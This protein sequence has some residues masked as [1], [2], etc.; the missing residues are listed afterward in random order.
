MLDIQDP[1]ITKMERQGYITSKP[2]DFQF[3]TL[4]YPVKKGDPALKLNGKMF[5]E[6]NLSLNEQVILNECG[7]TE[8]QF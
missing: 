4:G 3:D 6:E 8:T 1:R 5:S 2:I 7:A